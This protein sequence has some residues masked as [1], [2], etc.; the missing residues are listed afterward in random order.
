MTTYRNP[1]LKVLDSLLAEVEDANADGLGI[2]P[3]LAAEVAAVVGTH[4][5]AVRRIRLGAKS[6]ASIGGRLCDA[7][8]AAQQVVLRRLRGA[9]EDDED[10]DEDAG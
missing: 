1:E 10:D 4:G 7:V 9:V 2:S 3:G 8:F 6:P 5:I